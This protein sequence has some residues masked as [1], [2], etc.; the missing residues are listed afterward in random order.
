M[1]TSQ[2]GEAVTGGCFSFK[3]RRFMSPTT[4]RDLKALCCREGTGRCVHV[5]FFSPSG[6]VN[7]MVSRIQSMDLEMLVSLQKE[8]SETLLLIRSLMVRNRN[9]TFIAEGLI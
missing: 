7:L 2:R 5:G 4:A 8:C 6:V 1:V 9:Q 3:Q